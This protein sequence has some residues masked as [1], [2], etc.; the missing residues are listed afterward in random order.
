[1]FINPFLFILWG[2]GIP[3]NREI[4]GFVQH[5]DVSATILD[6]LGIE[7]HPKIDGRSLLPIV[8]GKKKPEDR[9]FIETEDQ[10][11]VLENGFKYIWHKDGSDELYDI[12]SDPMEVIN[13]IEEQKDRTASMQSTLFEWVASNLKGRPDPLT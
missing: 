9:I 1:M 6:L 8:G 3:K 7:D 12:A 2:R 10:R 13:L 11:A 4:G 5:V